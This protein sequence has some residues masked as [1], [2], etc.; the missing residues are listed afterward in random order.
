M[1]FLEESSDVSTL[2]RLNGVSFSILIMVI[3]LTLHLAKGRKYFPC[4][5]SFENFHA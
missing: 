1:P 4:G 2:G 3:L 5:P